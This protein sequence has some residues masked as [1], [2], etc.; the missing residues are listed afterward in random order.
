MHNPFNK[1]ETIV[2][3]III[4]ESVVPGK[5][6]CIFYMVPAYEKA[7]K[8]LLP[9]RNTHLNNDSVVINRGSVLR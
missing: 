5:P 8:L 1:S 9:G 4:S 6:L 7:R 3:D 2:V